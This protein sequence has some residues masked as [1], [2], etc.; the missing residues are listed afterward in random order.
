MKKFKNI[1][2]SPKFIDKLKWGKK[3]TLGLFKYSLYIEDE[4]THTHYNHLANRFYEG[5]SN[6]TVVLFDRDCINTLKKSEI[7][8]YEDFIIDSS[9]IKARN[10][11]E[12]LRKQQKWKE[13]IKKEKN[14]MIEELIQIIKEG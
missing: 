1:G 7:D 13:I 2:C 11:E 14:K 3:D 9:N 8:N 4:Y 5:L 10:Y 12:D 6:D